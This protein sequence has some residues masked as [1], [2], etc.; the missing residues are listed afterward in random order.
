MWSGSIARCSLP[1]LWA[2]AEKWG[3]AMSS[4]ARKCFYCDKPIETGDTCEP[5]K[6]YRFYIV[7]DGRAA[8]GDTD[9]AAVLETVGPMRRLKGA[10]HEAKVCWSDQGACLYS[11][12]QDGDKLT[13]ERFEGVVP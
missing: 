11:Y 2:L 1:V 9:K 10:M 12:A 8:D 5:C 7:Y 4:Q 13:D 3:Q 6:G